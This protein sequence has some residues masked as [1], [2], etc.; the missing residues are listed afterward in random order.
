VTG[1]GAGAAAALAAEREV[2][3]RDL[4]IKMLQKELASQGVWL[5][6]SQ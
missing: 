1:Q 2:P 5:R 4:K 3:V 6:R